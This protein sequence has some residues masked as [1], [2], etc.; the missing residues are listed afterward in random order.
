MSGPE[1]LNHGAMY[2][3]HEIWFSVWISAAGACTGPGEHRRPVARHIRRRLRPHNLA[4]DQ[5][6]Q[7]ST[8]KRNRRL[9]FIILQDVCDTFL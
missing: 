6:G 1:H 3:V 4:E 8:S 7:H 9:N 5:S 2:I